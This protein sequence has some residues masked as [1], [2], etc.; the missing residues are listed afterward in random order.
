M[1]M[2]LKKN[3]QKKEAEICFLFLYVLLCFGYHNA[4]VKNMGTV[5]IRSILLYILVIAAIRFTGKRQVGELQP[6]ELVLTIMISNIAAMPIEDTGIP[7]LAGA[8]PILTLISI[9]VI[10]SYLSSKSPKFETLVSGSP[11]IIIN[12]G[13][14]DQKALDDLRL[15][16][17]DVLEQLRQSA[18]YEISDA[19]LAIVETNGK[20]SIGESQKLMTMPKVPVVEN[21]K[22]VKH[23]AKYCGVEKAWIEDIIHQSGTTIQNIFLMTCNKKKE[24]TLVRKDEK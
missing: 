19:T 4:E 20:L 24:F 17:S 22:I 12:N 23:F 9:E 6:S 2:R 10:I 21:G 11:R 5:F 3:K 7:I 8:V 14:L 13:I 16:P 15:S 1:N 18:I